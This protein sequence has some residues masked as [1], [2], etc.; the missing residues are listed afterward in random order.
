MFGGEAVAKSRAVNQGNRA[1]GTLAAR[2]WRA[3][4]L[5][6]ALYPVGFSLAGVVL[7]GLLGLPMQLS[8]I[9][10]FP[11]A[12]QYTIGAVLGYVLAPFV[13]RL[14]KGA[15][16]FRGF[17]ADT[18]L[19]RVRPVGRLA[20]LTLTCV[21]I[22]I[23]CQ[24]TGS[25]VYKLSQGIPFSLRLVRDTFDLTPAI[26]PKSMLLFAQAFSALEEVALRGVLLTMLLGRHSRRTAIAYSAAAF[27][28]LHLLSVFA[29]SPPLLAF[30]QAAWAF[31]YGLAYGYLFVTTGSLLP[32]MVLHW[33]SNVVGA[34]LTAGW[35]AAPVPV[36][37]LYGVVFGYGLAALFTIL[38]VRL[39][40]G[41]WLPESDP[42]ARQSPA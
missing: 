35:A 5:M 27:G 30:A 38:W 4:L 41:R 22:L 1:G 16:T 32:P 18:G 14:P 10:A 7:Y 19:S 28:L 40:A 26:P 42:D 24:G 37:V 8:N 15:R 12:V 11:T 20:L 21:L 9:R 13:L 23:L 39:F 25:V 3:F 33:L 29:G 36:R 2:P 17:L 6:L 31:L 34:P